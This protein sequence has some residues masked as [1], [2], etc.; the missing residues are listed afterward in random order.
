MK[1][2][3]KTS[4]IGYAENGK[5]KIY[6]TDVKETVHRPRGAGTNLQV[7]GGAAPVW[8]KAR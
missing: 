8:R 5:I 4:N 3:H 2:E 7:G 1:T 6:S